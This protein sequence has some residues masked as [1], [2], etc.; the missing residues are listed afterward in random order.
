MRNYPQLTEQNTTR[1]FIETFG[2]LNKNIRISDGEFA[3]MEN[4]T[5]DYYPTLATRP[6]RGKTSIA[7]GIENLKPGV[8]LKD[9]TLLGMIEKDALYGVYV[10]NFSLVQGKPMWEYFIRVNGK[11]Y[12]LGQTLVE[13]DVPRQIVSMGAYIVIFPEG[14][15]FN[16]AD[17]SDWGKITK[18]FD[19]THTVFYLCEEDGHYVNIVDMFDISSQ[20]TYLKDL[21]NGSES[22]VAGANEY[23]TGPINHS[24]VYETSSGTAYY[25]H[26]GSESWQIAELY[27][28]FTCYEDI[29]KKLSVG[30][31]IRISGFNL[32]GDE[33]ETDDTSLVE[34]VF[35][36]DIDRPFIIKSLPSAN[37]IYTVL[38]YKPHFKK[39]VYTAENTL[40]FTT[41]FPKMDYVIES[42]NRLWGCRYGLNNNGDVV[43]EIYASKLGD[44]KN[45]E[46]FAG[47][48]TD[49]Y[50]ASLGSDGVFT[51][52]TSYL[53]YPLFF[54]QNCIHTVYGAYPATYQIQTTEC[55]GVQQG[56]SRS[57]VTLDGALLYKAV[58]GVC[59][60]TGSLPAE[61]GSQLNERGVQFTDAIAGTYH[62]KYYLAMK[63]SLSS[64]KDA[65]WLYVYDTQRGLWHKESTID[66]IQFCEVSTTDKNELYYGNQSSAAIYQIVG[67]N[68]TENENKVGWY[69]ET[70]VLG[71]SSPDKKY[72]SRLS[73]RLSMGVGTRVYV[74]AE[75]DSSGVWE[76]VAV[77]VG[78]TLGTFTIPIKPKR[79]DHLRL[80]LEGDDEVKIYSISKTLEQGSDI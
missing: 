53:G 21:V 47:V 12:T 5:S 1:D 29:R 70:G 64:D 25:W 72:I 46:T 31:A 49:S 32:S 74:S 67:N 60:Y 63:D 20:P 26:E 69:A 34:D 61:I 45:W 24:Y 48:S 50:T 65:H 11:S 77:I 2:G 39:R 33:T 6:K 44:F 17:T 79:C 3:D 71:C 52:A 41:N 18:N 68:E 37:S 38:D 8:T 15:Y 22:Q 62:N 7:D 30:D 43:N 56:C 57:I 16:T 51:G 58:G 80:R 40:S 42:D 14:Y 59:A 9:V 36:N 73:L 19:S 76:Q 28:G 55:R 27:L 23:V 75:Y 13:L 54:K 4:L 10:Y 35:R 66:V 78:S